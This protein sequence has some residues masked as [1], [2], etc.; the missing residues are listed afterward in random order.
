M[1]SSDCESCASYPQRDSSAGVRVDYRYI[2]LEEVVT[3]VLKMCQQ[4][5]E[6]TESQT[7]RKLAK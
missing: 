5:T 1:S 4:R 3:E 7:R 6:L 2:P